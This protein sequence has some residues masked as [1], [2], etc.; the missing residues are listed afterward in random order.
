M[1]RR[2]AVPRRRARAGTPALR[3]SCRSCPGATGPSARPTPTTHTFAIHGAGNVANTCA[4]RIRRGRDADAMHRRDRRAASTSR[5]IARSGTPTPTRTRRCTATTSPP[6]P[7]AWGAWRRPESELQ[8]LGDVTGRDVLELGCGA[9]QWS[10]ALAR[11]RR[12]AGRARRLDRTAPTRPQ[13]RRSTQRCRSCSRRR[14]AALRRALVRVGVLRSRRDELLRSRSVRCRKSARCCAEAGCSRSASPTRSC[15]SRGTSGAS[16]SHAS[17]TCDYDELGCI[18]F[19]EGTV[20]W[21]VAP[22]RW[23]R[24]AHAAT[25]SRSSACSS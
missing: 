10:A 16:D 13:A 19:G 18:D 20:D 5:G 11:A 23:M 22:G 15:T 4:V 17:C 14:V 12:A 1:S 2:L 9:A 24:A 21:V 25:G 7:L 3:A 8:V 6:A